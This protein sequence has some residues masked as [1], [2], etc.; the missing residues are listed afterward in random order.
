M[1]AGKSAS[2]TT[3][4]REEDMSEEFKDWQDETVKVVKNSKHV[5]A[6]WP[7]DREN[8]AGWQDV[9]VSGSKA[10]CLEYITKH[11]DGYGRLLDAKVAEQHSSAN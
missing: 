6:L 1:P 3:A 7:A 4:E 11:C 10:E 5:C 8:A 2:F 9:G